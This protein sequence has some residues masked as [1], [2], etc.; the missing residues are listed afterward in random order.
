MPRQNLQPP[1]QIDPV[2][3]SRRR[4]ALLKPPRCAGVG[5]LAAAPTPLTL[6]T[7]FTL[8]GFLR[9]GGRAV[10]EAARHDDAKNVSKREADLTRLDKIYDDVANPEL[11]SKIKHF[12]ATRR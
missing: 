11:R 12:A 7:D 10:L 9:R 8:D 2:E 4:R 5:S 3:S 1:P 6:A